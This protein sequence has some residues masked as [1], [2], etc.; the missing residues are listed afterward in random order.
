MEKIAFI[1]IEFHKKTKSS[2]FFQKILS[3]YFDVDIFYENEKS[4]Y[5]NNNYKTLIFWQWI[6]DFLDLIKIRDKKIILIP[7][8]DAMPLNR[9]AWNRYKK[10]NI[11][12]VCFCKKVYDFF[13]ENWFDCFYIQYYLQPLDYEVDY[14]EKKIF[15]RYRW[16]IKRDNVKKIIWNQN[17]SITIKNNPD[18]EYKALVIPDDEIKKYN[19]SFQNQFFK[20]KEQYLKLLSNHSI[21][22]APRKQ[23]WIWMS[24]L[25]SM[26]LWQCIIAYD[27]ATMNEYIIDNENWILTKFDKEI[28]LEDYRKI[29]ECA[30]LRYKTWLL[31]RNN[32]IRL[33]INFIKSEYSKPCNKITTM[34][35]IVNAMIKLRRVWLRLKRSLSR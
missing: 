35:Y 23:E 2:V 13:K 18:P 32:D 24:F 26:S 27:D 8:Y 9:I 10:F 16:N 34:D 11:K 4:R 33:C 5:I 30:K 28:N 7:M 1:D 14:S 25:E 6:P 31:K 29:G 20:D 12:V 15:F 22:I 17:V 3:E 19:I 21:F